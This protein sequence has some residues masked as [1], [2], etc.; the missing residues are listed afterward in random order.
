MTNS[1][2]F[3]QQLAVNEYWKQINGTVMLP[4]TKPCR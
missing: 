3:D 1:P 4:G 2:I